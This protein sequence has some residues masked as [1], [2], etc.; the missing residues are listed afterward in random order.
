[1]IGKGMFSDMPAM[2]EQA[3][4]LEA[5]RRSYGLPR[6][7]ENSLEATPN[8]ECPC[9]KCVRL[10]KFNV[11]KQITVMDPNKFT[12]K[13]HEAIRAASELA[14]DNGHAQIS[15]VHLAIALF[16]DPEGL[17][18]QAVL[19]EGNDETLRSILRVL[20]KKLVRQPSVEPPPER[21]FILLLQYLVMSASL[22]DGLIPRR[23]YKGVA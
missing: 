1:M 21:V 23:A 20:K 10:P 9:G 22:T 16:E 4:L 3:T 12:Q 17:G 7:C 11:W 14:Q 13:T 8:I 2:P 18:K 19:R 5:S 15:P 6:S